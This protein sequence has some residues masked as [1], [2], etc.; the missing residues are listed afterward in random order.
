MYIIIL[1][2]FPSLQ[3]RSWPSVSLSCSDLAV[4]LSWHCAL[5]SRSGDSYFRSVCL[6]RGWR[7][8]GPWYAFSLFCLFLSYF[9][10][11]HTLFVLFST[12]LLPN[13]L[14]M[15]INLPW[16]YSDFKIGNE[17]QIWGKTVIAKLLCFRWKKKKR[18]GNDLVIPSDFIFRI[19]SKAFNSLY[20]ISS[21]TFHHWDFLKCVGCKLLI[22]QSSN[23][24]S[25]INKPLPPKS[26]RT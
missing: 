20:Y 10:S 6:V 4:I 11:T 25:Q 3:K 14:L 13:L 15:L 26:L 16:L 18:K 7:W 1:F 8:I 17:K 5:V 9:A 23:Q 12:W 21:L 22:F 24:N 19:I 2:F